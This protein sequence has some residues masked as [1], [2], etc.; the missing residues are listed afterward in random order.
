[1]QCNN[2]SQFDDYK[3]Q[4]ILNGFVLNL[5][6]R[7]HFRFVYA[8]AGRVQMIYGASFPYFYTVNLVIE[9]KNYE[10]Q[11]LCL[12]FKLLFTTLFVS[13]ILILQVRKNRCF[14]FVNI[15]I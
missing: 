6:W 13:M 4:I 11:S 10:I 5:Q 15:Y 7:C 3:V 9:T 14:Y 2:Y 12:Y 8:S 1:M